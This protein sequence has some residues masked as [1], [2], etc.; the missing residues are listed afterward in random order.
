WHTRSKRDWSSDLCSSYLNQCEPSR[1]AQD[2]FD[3][4]TRNFSEG[5]HVNKD[6]ATIS[7]E[8]FKAANPDLVVGGF[9]CQDYSVARSLS[10]EKGIQGKKVCYFGKLNAY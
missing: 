1:K 3:C 9:P 5:I 6:I 8:E 4:Y 7:N 2:A 10:N